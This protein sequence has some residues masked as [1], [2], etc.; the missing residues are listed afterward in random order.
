MNII[1]VL[2]DPQLFAPHFKGDTWAPW[3]AFLAS[4]FALP[5]SD[6]DLTLYQAHTGR[7]TAPLVPF[8]E[9]AL[10]IGRRGG[11]SRVL[12]AVA[13][14]LACFRDYAPHLAPG[15]VPTIGVLAADRKQARTVF[16][17]TLGLLQKVPLLAGEI[18]DETADTIM[19]RNG[20][21][22]EI[23]TAS[24]RSSRGYTYAAV[25]ADESAFWRSDETSANP[26]S[27]I[28]RALRPGMATIPGAILLNASSPYRK[29][30]V[31]WDAY[32]RHYGKDDAPVLVWQAPTLAMNP[33][34]DPAIVEEAYESDPEAAEAEY[35]AQFRSDLSDFVSREA[36]EACVI[37]G[38]IELP[39]S[40]R[41]VAFVDP[42]GGSAD[43]M[44]LAIAHTEHGVAVL[45]CLRERKPPFSPEDV[46]TEFAAV[47]KSYG[48]SSVTGDRYGG[49]WPRERF[50]VHGITYDLSER[51]KA[52][53]YLDALPLLNSRKIE[54]LEHR[55]LISQLCGLERRTAR[56]GRDSIDHAPGAHDDLANAALGA[57]LLAGGGGAGFFDDT[58]SWVFGDEALGDASSTMSWVR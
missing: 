14:F 29:R 36:V 25:I 48:L 10:I 23:G 21:A 43:A 15:E 26:D 56:G 47:L 6:A 35:G 54:L 52:A 20:T 44:T 2:D 45:D 28:F 46:V 32:R 41:H 3:R 57:L 13:V 49:E 39:K 12:A 42:S 30:G 4:L 31:L 33:G 7:Q 8:K 5:M 1:E 9:A 58:Y 51:T 22:I 50:R 40:G 53:I 19:L 55:T 18:A 34:L 27:E 16:R 37:P 38:R 11:K 17:Y 24:L